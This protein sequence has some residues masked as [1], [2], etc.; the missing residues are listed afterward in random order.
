MGVLLGA[1]GCVSEAPSTPELAVAPTPEPPKPPVS[2]CDGLTTPEKAPF[3]LRLDQ[4]DPL[5]LRA[6][7][8][9]GSEQARPTLLAAMRPFLR[10]ELLHEEQGRQKAFDIL[11]VAELA[12]LY[13]CEGIVT[14]PAGGSVEL[15][16]STLVYEED[17]RTLQ[18]GSLVWR[19]LPAGAYQ[20][21]AQVRVH[22]D[23]C[24]P[25]GKRAD[26]WTGRLQSQQM[27]LEIPGEIPGSIH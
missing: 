6:T 3:T 8:C 17:R 21:R 24:E 18:F 2:V 11:S 12:G 5:T 16:R 14:I 27:T 4:P 15:I 20:A 9:N 13:P 23:R 10:L 19:D 7:L 22:L 25:E 1:G 26:L